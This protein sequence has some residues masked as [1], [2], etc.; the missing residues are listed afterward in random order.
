MTKKEMTLQCRQSVLFNLHCSS[1]HPRQHTKLEQV[2][3]IFQQV[4]TLLYRTADISAALEALLLLFRITFAPWLRSMCFCTRPFLLLFLCVGNSRRLLHLVWTRWESVLLQELV[5][6]KVY[7]CTKG[8]CYILGVPTL[9]GLLPNFS[10]GPP[11]Q[12]KASDHRLSKL[13][14]L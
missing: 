1:I 2:A 6:A 12:P 7:S 8:I 3:F 4:K 13:R 11:P 14:N 10:R 5:A 9:H